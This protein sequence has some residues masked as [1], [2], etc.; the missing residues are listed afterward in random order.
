MNSGVI[1]ICGMKLDPWVKGPNCFERWVSGKKNENLANLKMRLE[2]NF[3]GWL[4]CSWDELEQI[5]PF[6]E[7]W[8]MHP[9]SPI[10]EVL[11]A[12]DE[13]LERFGKLS[14]FQ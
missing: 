9:Q 2:K 3:D 13:I 11:K 4:L 10:E 8:F 6:L 1:E 5:S 12:A 14:S 7:N